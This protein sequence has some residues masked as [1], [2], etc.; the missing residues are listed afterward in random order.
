VLDGAGAVLQRALSLP[1]GASRTE[2][3]AGSV[4]TWFYP[5][6]HGDVIVQTDDAGTRQ[7]TRSRLDPFEQLIDPATGNIATIEMGARQYVAALGRFLEVDPVEGGV[8]NNYD[9]PADPI[10]GLDLTGL[11]CSGVSDVGCN[12]GMNISSILIGMGD[13]I[14][15]CLLCLL[16]GETSLTGLARNALG[17]EGTAA[18]AAEFQSNG[19]YTFG[20]LWA[21]AAAGSFGAPAAAA[22]V[23]AIRSAGAYATANVTE[24]VV[25]RGL[26]RPAVT[27]L[28]TVLA[29]SGAT[30]QTSRLFARGTG[31]LNKG[32]LR[33][34]WNWMGTRA[35][36]TNV[37][38]IG[39]GPARG[40]H[41][42]IG[43][44]R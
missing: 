38:R 26:S 8:S 10:N 4:A 3:V 21:G 30:S 12:I 13:T 40:S 44:F 43:M 32:N 31:L 27:T 19:F 5:N 17:G 33:I 25:V 42:D 11:A 20:S 39:I 9:Y 2:L 29:R 24:Q 7:G 6:L 41:I 23:G 35:N 15:M 1:G 37:F 16:G 34:G 36:G 22:G 28:G 18:V 14:T